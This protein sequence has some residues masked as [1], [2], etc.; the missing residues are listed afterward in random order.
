MRERHPAPVGLCC[1]FFPIQ[2]GTL[3]KVSD[4]REPEPDFVVLVL[5]TGDTSKVETEV[6][7]VQVVVTVTLERQSC[8]VDINSGNLR[9]TVTLRRS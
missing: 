3:H 8:A 1:V 7:A 4:K 2:Y 6:F 9:N 5:Q